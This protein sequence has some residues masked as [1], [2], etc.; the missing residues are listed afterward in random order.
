MAATPVTAVHRWGATY[1]QQLRILFVRSL[2]TRRF[3]SLSMQ[4]ML[5]LVVVALLS[6]RGSPVLTWRSAWPPCKRGVLLHYY[7]LVHHLADTFI[8][9]K[10]WRR[11][12]HA[13]LFWFNAGKGRFV[14]DGTNIIGLLFFELI[15]LAFRIMFT[16]RVLAV[17]VVM[18][19]ERR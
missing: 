16:V 3:E 19:L 10:S 11:S 7:I 15:F 9:P 2:K 17:P 8:T 4:D 13:G 6:G 1:L 14:S 18:S 12:L 5:Q